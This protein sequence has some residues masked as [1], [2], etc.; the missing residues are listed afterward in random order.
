M[1]TP[2]KPIIA[3][4]CSV[5]CAFL[6]TACGP[7]SYEKAVQKNIKRVDNPARLEDARFIADATSFNLLAN[8]M[9][10]LA[11]T[12][13]YS[14]ALVSLANE[15]IKRHKDLKKELKRLAR[16]EKLLLP[17]EMSPKHQALMNELKNTDRRAFDQTY[18]RILNQIAEEDK[19]MYTRL[20]T[21]GVSDEI[22]SFAAKQLGV[23]DAHQNRL[24]A[25]E[26]ELLRTY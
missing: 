22:R 5:A 8:E 7:L 12:S 21:A 6:I 20:A 13:G 14:A 4:V 25:I 23:F 2:Y 24:R 18:V 16:K 10:E 11:T 1:K 26:A 17:K 9:A 15:N 3:A 19:E